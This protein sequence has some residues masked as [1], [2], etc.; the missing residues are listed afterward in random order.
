MYTRERKGMFHDTAGYD[1][2]AMSAGLTPAFVK[3]Y[4]HPFC[5]YHAPQALKLRGEKDPS[6]YPPAVTIFQPETGE[7]MVGQAVFVP[8]DFTGT[9]S[10]Y[11]MHSYIIPQLR[12]EEWI[13]QPKMLFQV[14]D[15]QTAYDVRNG[16]VLPELED[17]PFNDS[18]KIAEILSMLGISLADFKQLLFAVMTSISGKKKVFISLPVPLQDYTNYALLL[19]ESLYHYLPYEYRRKLG[20]ITFTSEPELRNYIHVTFFEQGTLNTGDRSIEKQLIFDFADGCIAGVVRSEPHKYLEFVSENLSESNGIEGFLTFAEMALTGLSEEQRLSFVNYDQLTDLYLTL[21]LDDFQLYFKNKLEFLDVLMKFLQEKSEEKPE[22]TVLFL[23]L[24][25]LEET[26]DNRSFALSYMKAVVTINSRVRCEE[27]VL[28]L[29]NTLIFYQQDPLYGELWK[30]IERDRFT[31]ESLLFFIDQH[32]EYEYLLELYLNFFWDNLRLGDIQNS[33][34]FLSDE[35]AAELKEGTVRDMYLILNAL[36]KL[37]TLPTETASYHLKPLT[38]NARYQLSLILQNLLSE[39]PA[40][41]PL[42]LIFAAFETT[43][44]N[45]DYS[46]VFDYIISHYDESTLFRFIKENAVLVETDLLF[47]RTLTN[48]L[49]THPKSI[50]KNKTWRKSLQ[51]LN[52]VI[53]KHLVKEI[54][55]ETANPLVRFLKRGAENFID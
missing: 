29:I 39:F 51:S 9:R 21:T 41:I 45:V 5:L 3:K 42:Q 37:I 6:H 43:E 25:H 22:L 49:V 34:D 40:P 1:T 33:K 30:T 4:I 35:L 16:E 23:K 15:F 11:F 36:Y 12:K 32:Q 19:L 54:E 14:R 38:R 48:Y 47:R 7:L 2:I 8:A 10:T 46:K 55:M 18:L 44:E 50:W 31:F 17:I 13:H 26:A 28:F 52:D 27:V 53:F 20:A 24:L